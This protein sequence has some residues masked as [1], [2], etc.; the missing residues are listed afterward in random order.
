MKGLPVAF[1]CSNF[2]PFQPEP[3]FLKCNSQGLFHCK[4]QKPNSSRVI[5]ERVLDS[6]YLKC[7]GVSV[8]GMAGSRDLINSRQS[9]FLSLSA[10]IS[11]SLHSVSLG[12]FFCFALISFSRQAVPMCWQRCLW[13]PRLTFLRTHILFPVKIPRRVSIGLA[14]F[15]PINVG[16]RI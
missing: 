7:S 8:S 16:R 2:S 3:V 13:V 6:Y 12:F 9:L 1:N 15:V 4:W 10:S 11:L 5:L 14:W